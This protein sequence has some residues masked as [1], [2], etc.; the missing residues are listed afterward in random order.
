MNIRPPA[1]PPHTIGTQSNGRAAGTSSSPVCASNLKRPQDT[2]RQVQRHNAAPQTPASSKQSCTCTRTATCAPQPKLH[3]QQAGQHRPAQNPQAHAP[4]SAPAYYDCPQPT[5]YSARQ[6]EVY[7]DPNPGPV[8]GS[9]PLSPPGPSN[10]AIAQPRIRSQSLDL[11]SHP[12][13]GRKNRPSMHALRPAET[14]QIPTSQATIDRQ[15]HLRPIL[16]KCASPL[17]MVMALTMSSLFN[18]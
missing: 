10:V 1:P 5:A 11:G 3:A 8:P 18:L 16:K 15:F 6:Q 2:K 13:M 12:S 4:A 17:A 7:D 14:S 9:Y